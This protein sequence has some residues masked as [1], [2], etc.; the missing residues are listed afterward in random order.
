MS[1][2]VSD[3]MTGTNWSDLHLHT[4]ELGATWTRHT[5]TPS[6]RWYIFNNKVHCGVA[7]I[8]Y[9]SG[10]PASADYSVQCD[11]T[12]FTDITAIGLAGR[13]STSVATLYYTYYNG[14]ELVLAK[15]INGAI[16][17]LNAVPSVMAAGNTYVLKLEMIGSAIKVFVDGVQ[18][19]SVT[20]STITAAGKAGVRSAASNDAWTGKHIDNYLAFDTSVATVA[21]SRLAGIIG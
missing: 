13:I 10:T 11:Y 12:F 5:T 2:F 15:Q 7:G 4:G 8:L 20:D 9:A 14:D 18:R 17:S 19:I 16:T 6:S 21:R 3:S 1:N